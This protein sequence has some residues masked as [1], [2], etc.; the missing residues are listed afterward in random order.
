MSPKQHL[1]WE[2]LQPSNSSGAPGTLGSLSP[3]P[4]PRGS[5]C[6]SLRAHGDFLSSRCWGENSDPCVL[7]ALPG[8]GKPRESF[9]VVW[10][11]RDS[12]ASGRTD[13]VT[14]C[15]CRPGPIAIPPPAVPFVPC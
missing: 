12:A 7:T 6:L 9:P 13:G 1:T 10:S 14:L 2:L 15:C 8:E 4:T 3:Q 11:A 5:H